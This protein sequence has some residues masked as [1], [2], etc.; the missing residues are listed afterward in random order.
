MKRIFILI[1]AVIFSQSLF[2][3]K[4]YVDV[5]VISKYGN[6]NNT[7]TNWRNA[8]TFLSKYIFSSGDTVYV[9]EG[10]YAMSAFALDSTLAGTISDPTVIIGIGKVILSQDSDP[11]YITIALYPKADHIHFI[12]ITFMYVGTALSISET[13]TKKL[14]WIY[15][16]GTINNSATL[17]GIKFINCSFISNSYPSGLTG[18][19]IGTSNE[20]FGELEMEISGCIFKNMQRGIGTGH[21]SSSNNLSK[22]SNIKIDHCTFYNQSINTS[23]PEIA[24]YF[25]RNETYTNEGNYVNVTNSIF[26]GFYR[27]MY[28][29]TSST[30]IVWKVSYSDF[31][32]NTLVQPNSYITVDN[33]NFYLN[34]QFNSI[35]TFE[36]MHTSPLLFISDK[37]RTIG[38]KQYSAIKIG[39]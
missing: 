6:T 39:F 24:I 16:Y 14:M 37:N 19:G 28:N 22:K 3:K 29:N 35:E 11:T 30:Q 4:V 21:S 32:L 34:P 12:N 10:T 13:N 2:A 31:Y 15:P 20:T 38:A 5:N 33:S 7:G 8:Y 23:V 26:R 9:A 17:K 27:A 18:I 36:L 25:K 1:L